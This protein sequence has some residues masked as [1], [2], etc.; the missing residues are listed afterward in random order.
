VRRL[1]S[2][3]TLILLAALLGV[4]LA[5]RPFASQPQSP[6]TAW[7]Q[8]VLESCDPQDLPR[9]TGLAVAAAVQDDPSGVFAATSAIVKA[10]PAS[11]D[12]HVALHYTALELVKQHHPKELLRNYEPVCLDGFSH[13]VVEGFA[14]TVDQAAFDADVM[15]LCSV[16]TPDSPGSDTCYHGIGH[17]F[18]IKNPG[19]LSAAARRCAEFPADPAVLC[20]QGVFM[21]YTNEGGPSLGNLD[22]GLSVKRLSPDEAVSLCNDLPDSPASVCW[23]MAW[24]LFD[25]ATVDVIASMKSLCESSG[26]F[27]ESCY[28]GLG[29]AL[30][31]RSG[32]QPPSDPEAFRSYVLTRAAACGSAGLP[33]ACLEGVAYSGTLW[34]GSFQESLDEYPS[35]CG[36]LPDPRPETIAACQDGESKVPTTPLK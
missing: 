8:H 13:G 1:A 25:P 26:R 17:A 34:W 12:C 7:A 6:S 11:Y 5:T 21:A 19:S 10:A 14:L 3:A 27:A 28:Q 2:L 35:I 9:C 16:F 33:L 18:M 20:A 22:L 4:L 15:S 30:F 31:F 29:L 23:D 36:L 24:L 32:S